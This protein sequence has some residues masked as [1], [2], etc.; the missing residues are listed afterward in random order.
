MIRSEAIQSADFFIANPPLQ[1]KREIVEY[2]GNQGF[3]V[4]RI[5]ES[6]AA[7]RQELT[8]RNILIRGEH[9]QDYNG[10]SDLIISTTSWDE[11]DERA[12]EAGKDPGDYLASAMGVAPYE[13]RNFNDYFLLWNDTVPDNQTSMS[14][15]ENIDDKD[16][17][18]IY[19]DPARPQTNHVLYL[20]TENRGLTRPGLTRNYVLYDRQSDVVESLVQDTGRNIEPA[21]RQV[22]NLFDQIA[23]L[24]Y[25]DPQHCYLAEFVINQQDTPYFVQM[26]RGRDAQEPATHNVDPEDFSD[27]WYTA[28]M[29]IGSTEPEGLVIPTFQ[30]V[31]PAQRL[32][33]I[34]ALKAGHGHFVNRAAGGLAIE[35]LA[36]NTP[37]YIHGHDGQTVLGEAVYGHGARSGLY[38][39]PLSIVPPKS[40]VEDHGDPRTPNVQIEVV[41]DGRTGMFRVLA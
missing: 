8:D 9:P 10:A 33:A 34:D 19:R 39:P 18:V 14:F 16:K 37:L 31:S 40:F 41:S 28:D 11:L 15:W 4:P 32:P 25:F 29:V 30:I 17:A 27:E 35:F 13:N 12:A 1:P 22:S 21:V 5:F 20:A 24:P 26:H 2:V 7:A 38:R 36:L 23:S 3:T 6:F